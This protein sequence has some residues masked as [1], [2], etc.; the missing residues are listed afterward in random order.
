[1]TG[2]GDE[3]TFERQAARGARSGFPKHAARRGDGRDGTT[4]P[5]K[6]D[7]PSGS[8]FAGEGR[9]TDRSYMGSAAPTARHP[10]L[11]PVATGTPSGRALHS[12]TLRQRD[13][14]SFESLDWGRAILNPP[15][16]GYFS[17]RSR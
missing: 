9:N 5:G 1:M 8:G 4:A 10:A 16:E 11:S 3:F 2:A 17:V 7:D 15:A 14:R 6:D 13:Q 12:A